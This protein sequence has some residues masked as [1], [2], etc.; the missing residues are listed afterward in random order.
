MGKF[1][2]TLAHNET[3]WSAWLQMS[4]AMTSSNLMP[5]W[6]K[7]LPAMT[8]IM[9]LIPKHYTG[10]KKILKGWCAI[11][12]FADKL[13]NIDFL[14]TSSG[15]PV[16]M[17]HNDNFHDL[18]ERF[19]AVTTSYRELLGFANEKALTFILDR[20]IYGL[21][22]FQKIMAS[23]IRNYFITWEKGYKGDLWDESKVSGSFDE[24]KCR[25]SSYDLLRYCF[26]FIDG[27]WKK[28]DQIR[29]I[30]VRATNPRGRTVEVAILTN[31]LKRQAKEVVMLIFWRWVKE[32]DFKYLNIHFG[33]NEI[34]SYGAIAYKE[35]EKVVEDK[36]VKSGAYKALEVKKEKLNKQ[37]K[38]LLLRQ[39][40]SLKANAKRDENIKELTL[41]LKEIKKLRDNTEKE[42]SRLQAAIKGNFYK[43][44]VSQKSV[45]DSIK[46]LTRN[47]F[48]V[49]LEPFKQ[50]YDNYRDDHVLFR[51]LT[52]AHGC[53]RLGERYVDVTLFPTAHY[54]PK[55]RRIIETVLNKINEENPRLPDGSER[56]IRFS[57]GKKE[58]KLF[59][60]TAK[61]GFPKTEPG[62]IQKN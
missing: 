33:I 53:I 30:I 49:M 56:I 46:I 19:F 32:N 35:L 28:D 17:A 16:Y 4:K 21:K 36:Q 10:V 39:H 43:L 51:N 57:L 61:D 37:L 48:Y 11:L 41:E 25:N 18:R 34:T 58:N 26:E 52:R 1:L 14:H 6:Y 5:Q 2:E 9:I 24:F 12:R 3:N 15:Y 44:N 60:V 54:Q 42:E 22:V 23:P 40:Q 59:T 31:D 55:V 50:L 8:S 20:G 62:T 38:A 29:Q 45:M 47:M 7:P 27:I 13:I